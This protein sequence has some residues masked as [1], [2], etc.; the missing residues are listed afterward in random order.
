MKLQLSGHRFAYEMRNLCFLFF[1]G[2][3]VDETAPAA[4]GEDAVYTRLKATRSGLRALCA[5]RRGGKLF[6]SREALPAHVSASSKE[7]ERALGRAFYR[8][9]RQA[10]GLTPPWGTLTGIRPVKL[11]RALLAQEMTEAQAVAELERDVLLTPEKAALL[12]TTARAEEKIVA[13]SRPESFSLYVGIP[14]CPSRCAYC[15]FVSHDIEK[16]ARLV[17]RYVELLCEEIAETGRLAQRLGLSLST[18]YIGG[19]TPTSLSAEQLRAIMDALR[20][21]FP[22]DSA[23]E[24]TVE[25]GR[26]DTVTPGKLDALLEGGA[27]RIS[28]NPQ[29]MDD[30]ILHAVGRRHTARQTLDAFALARSAGFPHINMDLIAGLPGD[31]PEG[32]AKTLDEVLSLRPEAITVHTLAMKRAARLSAETGFYRRGARPE[33]NVF[34]AQAEAVDGALRAAEASLTAA[35]YA[36]YYLYRQ[37]NT[38]GNL[39]NVGWSLP[40]SEG[41]YNVF[42]MDETHTILACGASGVTKLRQPGGDRIERIF[43]CKYPY[44]YNE[45]FWQIVERK[46]QVEVFYDG[47]HRAGKNLG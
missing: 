4:P 26:P 18:I 9:A 29:T 30:D 23:L 21:A 6:R 17:P 35:G 8:A 37:R 12:V 3:A 42:I 14:F 28:V 10:T 22:V 2:E 33:Q 39:E 27:R 41:L 47:T 40:G 25:A 5:V 7:A 15:S 43:N 19:G 11:L 16:A 36:P 31:T 24:F 46:R 13:L 1:P 20:A 32:F 34:A 44:E 38:A 45:R